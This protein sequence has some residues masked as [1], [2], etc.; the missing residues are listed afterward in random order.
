MSAPEQELKDAQ[1]VVQCRTYFHE[2]G[3]KE[4]KAEFRPDP[5]AVVTLVKNKTTKHAWGIEKF[6]PYLNP[7]WTVRHLGAVPRCSTSYVLCTI[8]EHSQNEPHDTLYA[9]IVNI[10][11]TTGHM[12][13]PAYIWVGNP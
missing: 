12:S 11:P 9:S 6:R 4:E 10:S 5:I 2:S 3:K 1:Y 8:W 13:C 7:K